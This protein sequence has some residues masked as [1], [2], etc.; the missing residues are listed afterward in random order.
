MRLVKGLATG[1][2]DDGGLYNWKDGIVKLG[3]HD[4]SVSSTRN[5]FLRCI[6]TLP[7]TFT[8]TKCLSK[9]DKIKVSVFFRFCQTK[10]LP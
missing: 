2:Y 10:I 4:S 7:S 3:I 8:V 6:K 5:Q 1:D 9:Q